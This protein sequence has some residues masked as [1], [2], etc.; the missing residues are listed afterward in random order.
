MCSDLVT[1]AAI[2][3]TEKLTAIIHR[4]SMCNTHIELFNVFESILAPLIKLDGIF[5]VR[6]NEQTSNGYIRSFRSYQKPNAII[7]LSGESDYYQC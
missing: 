2:P 6:F 5:I 1:Y 3:D 7:T 4:L